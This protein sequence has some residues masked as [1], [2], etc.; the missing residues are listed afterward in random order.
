[1]V[2][3]MKFQDWMIDKRVLKRNIRHGVVSREDYQK[4]VKS[5]PDLSDQI[6]TDDDETA[7]S[8]GEADDEAS[9]SKKSKSR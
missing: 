8:N 9:S 6:A 4:Y 5:L 1:M 3:Y 7:E 2:N